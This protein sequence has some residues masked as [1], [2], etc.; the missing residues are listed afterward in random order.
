[1][2]KR[3]RFS[4]RPSAV[5]RVRLRPFAVVIIFVAAGLPNVLAGAFNYVHNLSEI[6]AK[7]GRLEPDFQLTQAAIN[8]VAYPVGAVLFWYLGYSVYRKGIVKLQS[9]QLSSER[10]RTLRR[11]ALDLGCLVS[12][13]SIVEWT[14]AACVYPISLRV[15]QAEMPASAMLRFFFSLLLCGLVAA[16]YPF[17]VVTF[18]SLRSL[19]PVFVVSDYEGASS[20]ADLLRRVGR[21]NAVYLVVA[22]SAPFLAITALIADSWINDNVLPDG[23]ERSMAVFSAIGVLGLPWLFWLSHAIRTDLATLSGVLATDERGS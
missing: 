20:D 12:L 3:R 18:F 13:I 10:G 7:L 6:V 21:W 23:A 14:I 16:A 19:Y 8:A 2:R 15:I 22:A 9:G 4:S 17:F 11:R 1:M 5:W